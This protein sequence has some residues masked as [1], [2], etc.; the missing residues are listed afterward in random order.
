VSKRRQLSQPPILKEQDE[1]RG[2]KAM[3]AGKQQASSK[4]VTPSRENNN[5]QYTCTHIV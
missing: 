3:M 2:E 5:M 1:R 4:D